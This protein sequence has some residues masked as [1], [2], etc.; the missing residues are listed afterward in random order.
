MRRLSLPRRIMFSAV[1]ACGL[2]V[3]APLQAQIYS[4]WYAPSSSGYG[5][6]GSFAS[7]PAQ[8]YLN[9]MSEVI[10]AQGEANANNAK[11]AIDGETARSKYIENRLQW[12]RT[13]YE[14]KGDYHEYYEEN[15]AKPGRE[16]YK[17][18]LAHAE[19]GV[20]EKL[21]PSTVDYSVGGIEWP[22]PLQADQFG[23]ARR[24]VEE[25]LSLRAATGNTSTVVND[26][27]QAIKRLQNLLKG[28]ISSMNTQE[29][30]AARN[31]LESLSYE[32][33]Y[34]KD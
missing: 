17:N 27:A 2:L 15:Y 23:E 9:G 12:Q 20:P 28:S 14:M 10:R 34:S 4:P 33:R 19:S 24:E 16:K 21:S 11:A 29:Y 22:Q 31:F 6:G 8:G 5:Y 25:L 13:Y 7:T 26:L 30:I 18:Y 32:V 1:I 3:P